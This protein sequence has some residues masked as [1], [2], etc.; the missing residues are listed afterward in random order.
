MI[1]TINMT[2]IFIFFFQAAPIDFPCDS[3]DDSVLCLAGGMCLNGACQCNN[4]SIVENGVCGKFLVLLY[5]QP[6][7]SLHYIYTKSLT[8]YTKVI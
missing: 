3:T 2:C 8:I 6:Y 4:A 1:K 5:Y 7:I